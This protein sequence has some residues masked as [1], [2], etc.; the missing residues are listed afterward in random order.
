M[1]ADQYQA[2]GLQGLYDRRHRIAT[3]ARVDML[4]PPPVRPAQL[5]SSHFALCVVPCSARLTFVLVAIGP[6]FAHFVLSSHPNVASSH[7]RLPC[8]LDS[9][10]C[11][12]HCS[13]RRPQLKVR[14]TA[15]AST[16]ATALAKGT[17]FWATVSPRLW[18]TA[19]P[20][21]QVTFIAGLVARR[22]A[23]A[24]ASLPFLA[25]ASV[26]LTRIF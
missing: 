16:T 26:G 1:T 22:M 9:V 3:V 13:R 23:T 14:I 17:V 2:S 19:S 21:S 7:H 8:T 15:G 6:N 20:L 18:A 11:S 24:S 10:P 5:S 12:S 4:E 25:G